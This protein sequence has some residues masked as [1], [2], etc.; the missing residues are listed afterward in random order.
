M[1]F[2]GEDKIML[3]IIEYGKDEYAFPSLVVLGCFDAIHAGHRELFKKAR[4]QAK[5]NG[6]DLGVM[7]FRDG[8]GGKMVYSFEER[9]SMLSSFGVKFVLVIDYTPQ[10]K[11]TAPL[12][13]LAAIEDKVNVKAYMSGKD[14]RFGKGA[15]GKSSTLKNYAEDEENGVWYMPVKDVVSNGE[16]I[17]TT[18]IKHCLDEGNVSRAGELL[19]EP[20]FVEGTVAEGAHRGS[21]ILGFP[22]VNINYPA[23]KY[24]VKYGVYKVTVTVDGE[25]YSGIA[26]FGGRPTFDDDNIVLEVHIKD[27]SGDIYGKQVKIGFVGYMR[28]IRKFADAGALAAQLA[29]DKAALALSDEQFFASYPLQEGEEAVEQPVTPELEEQCI[30][31]SEIFEGSPAVQPEAE[32]ECVHI[33][34]PAEK[35]VESEEVCVSADIP[36]EAVETGEDEAMQEA[37]SEGDTS[38]EAECAS[39]GQAEVAQE[40]GQPAVETIELSAEMSEIQNAEETAEQSVEESAEECAE[41]AHETDADPVAVTVAEDIMPAWQLLSESIISEHAC[42][43]ENSAESGEDEAD[44]V[45]EGESVE[46]QETAETAEISEGALQSEEAAEEPVEEE[47]PEATEES[48][49]EPVEEEQPE[50]TEEPVEEPAEEEQPEVTE[51]PAEE[52]VEEEQPEATEESAEESAEEEQPEVTEESVEEP[53]EEEQPEATEEFVEEPVEEEQSEATEEPA[54][55]PVEEEQSEVTEESVEEPVEEE[56]SEAMEEP[57]EEPAEEEQPE[58]TEEPAE[59]PVEEEQPEATEESA[60]ESA[61]E[62][63][64]EVTEESVEEPVEEEQPEEPELAEEVSEEPVEEEQPEETEEAAEADAEDQEQDND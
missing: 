11:D 5:I 15:K 14:F 34:E 60:E 44:G 45:T 62:E 36:G 2:K 64:P 52:S 37:A 13:F 38:G 21:E 23:W 27:F 40:C 29:Q 53:V 17:S 51:E 8:K 47:Q 63:Q 24:P 12:D 9:L 35:I 56:Q 46:V 26:N 43:A 54:E 59:E 50:V 4:L 10:F 58:E 61:E 25:V 7:M 31:P 3:D 49:E 57:V 55:E 28:S 33:E 16:K 20:F 30:E 19:G 18:L 41:V 1:P 22:T 6:L 39:D 42:E 48:V 32:V